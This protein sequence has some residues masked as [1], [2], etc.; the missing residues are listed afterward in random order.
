MLA[1]D[2]SIFVEWRKANGFTQSEVAELMGVNL[3]TVKRWET[4]TRKILPLI[5]LVMAAIDHNLTPVG[6][7]AMHEVGRDP[8]EDES[9]VPSMR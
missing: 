7:N 1:M 3:T 4:G 2:K 8:D 6:I 5:G 9:D